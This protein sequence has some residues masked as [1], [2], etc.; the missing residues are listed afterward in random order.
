[1]TVPIPTWGTTTFLKLPRDLLL[2]VLSFC[3]VQTACRIAATCR[4]LYELV[5]GPKGRWAYWMPKYA[6]KA[7][8]DLHRTLYAE[9]P[10]KDLRDDATGGY[11]PRCRWEPCEDLRLGLAA[12]ESLDLSGTWAL[13]G[14]HASGRQYGYTITIRQ[15]GHRVFAITSKPFISVSF[16]AIRGTL[17]TLKQYCRLPGDDEQV[18]DDVSATRFV[19]L[20]A[21]RVGSERSWKFRLAPLPPRRPPAPTSPTSSWPSSPTRHAPWSYGW[22]AEILDRDPDSFLV[23]PP[24]SWGWANIC[25]AVVSPSGAVMS[26]AWI[27]EV[28][29]M[30]LSDSRHTGHFTA[31]KLPDGTVAAHHQPFSPLVTHPDCN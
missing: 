19:P 30:T 21:P 29:G 10:P 23:L 18:S 27:Q 11:F 22:M 26:G 15:L 8:G 14:S 4:A 1:M 5:V 2:D 31:V 16:G 25:S 28:S 20:L 17:L 3:D 12:I 9:L 13:S 24:L 6:S 7:Y